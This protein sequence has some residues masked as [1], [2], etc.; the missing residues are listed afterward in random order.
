MPRPFSIAAAV[1][2]IL[3]TEPAPSPARE[4]GCAWTVSSASALSPYVR[5]LAIAMTLCES[6]PGLI[7]FITFAM[8]S[9]LALAFAFSPALVDAWTCGSRVVLMR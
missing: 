6:W 8:P 2:K 4:Y 7:T 3:K 1:V 5:L 9:R